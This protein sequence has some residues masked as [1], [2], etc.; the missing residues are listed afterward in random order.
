[1]PMQSAHKRIQEITA[2]I[3]ERSKPTREAY[4]GRVRE[5]ASNK[6]KRAVLGCANLAHGFAACG[7]HDKAALTGDEIPNLGIITAYNDMLSAHPPFETFPQLIKQAARA[8]GGA[9]EVAGG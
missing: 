1:M 4:L 2:R 9:A 3:R 6:P 7:P 8:A 5:A